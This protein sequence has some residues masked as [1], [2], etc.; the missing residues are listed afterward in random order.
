MQEPSQFAQMLTHYLALL[1][2]F[3]AV[4]VIVFA[5]AAVYLSY[6]DDLGKYARCLGNYIFPIGFFVSFGGVFLT[7][8]YSEVLHY[9]PCDLCWFQRVFLYPQ[10]FIFALA[11]YKKDRSIFPYTLMLSLIGF[12]I[13]VYHHMLQIGYN[14]YKPCSTAPFAVDCA[15]P[16]FIEFGFVTFPLMAVV[17]FGFLALLI[18]VAI[19]DNKKK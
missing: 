2:I 8:F 9:A 4:F 6:R 13:A 12:A 1:T 5:L 19:T 17:L 18:F 14:I 7:L 3:G 16:S 15:K 11:W 10:A